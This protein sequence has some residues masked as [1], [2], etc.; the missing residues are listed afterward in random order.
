MSI[1][2]LTA[3]RFFLHHR[4]PRG[5]DLHTQNRY[6]VSQ[7]YRQIQLLGPLNLYLLASGDI[8]SNRLRG[9]LH[10]LG[11]HLQVGEQFDLLAPVIE[12]RLLAH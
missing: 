4:Y 2:T 10:I 7:H 6:R 1:L 11:S 3:H 5:V 9:A 8:L 12:R